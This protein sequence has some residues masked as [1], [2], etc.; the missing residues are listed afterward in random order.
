MRL[1]LPERVLVG[2]DGGDLG[3]DVEVEELQAVEHVLGA[4]PLHGLDDLDGGEAELRAVS[5]RLDPLAGPLGGETRAHAQVRLDAQLARGLQDEV[6]L[7]EA[8]HHDDRA[9]LPR[10]WA[11]SAVST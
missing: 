6:D 2:A 10:R 7:A 8:V 9:A 3:A 11:R 1:G 5:R 4:Q